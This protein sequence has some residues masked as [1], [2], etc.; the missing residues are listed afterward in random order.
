MKN[1]PYS[2][3][4]SL[5]IFFLL[6]FI[7]TLPAYILIGLAAKS[8]I[9][10][11]E[12]APAFIPLS[13]LAPISAALFLAF[14][15]NGGAG[16]KEL[17]KRSF[18]YR[19]I[20][21]KDWYVPTLFLA[22]FLVILALGIS[23]LMGLPLIDVLFPIVAAP[24]MFFLFFVGSLGEEVGWM[25]YAFEPM[26][27][28]WNAFKAAL[29][30]GLIIALWHVPFYYFIIADPIMFTAQ[31]LFPFLLRMLLV[32]IFNNT[33][34]SVFAVILF[35]T[36]NNVAS[37]GLPVNT[38]ILNLVYAIAVITVTFLWGSETMANFRWDKANNKVREN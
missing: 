15:K 17:L 23:V 4:K 10:S 2:K 27:N 13:S 34:K 21:N 35:H 26:Q 32:W 1:R 16:A 9:L 12:I 38:I 19:R 8:V 5:A 37:F 18:D 20:A 3:N 36:M 31:L 33:G 7:F 24:V 6:T 25:G 29:L 22:P 11:P 30:L 14:K 28:K